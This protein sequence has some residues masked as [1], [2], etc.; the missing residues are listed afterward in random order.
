MI[1]T[2]TISPAIDYVMHTGHIISGSTNRSSKEEYYWGGKGINVS[3]M[4]KHLGIKSTALGFIAGFTGR[5]LEEG[6]NDQGIFTDFVHLENGMTR[7]N[8]K[9]KADEETEINGQGAIPGISDFNRL[10]DKLSLLSEGDILVIS[11]TIPNGLPVDTYAKILELFTVK[12]ILAAVDTSGD[13]LLNTLKHKPFLIKPNIDELKEIFGDTIEPLDGARKLH[14]AG[15]RNVIVSMGAKGAILLAEN[16][17][18]YYCGV[19][20]GEML[21]T[22]G[23]GDSM[24]AGFLAGYEET[25]DYRHALNLSVAAG[26]ATAF[27][28]GLAIKSTI[29]DCLTEIE[30]KQSIK[31][32]TLKTNSKVII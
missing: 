6:L 20:C 31:S 22:V 4:L 27:T 21:N 3:V 17:S 7:I 11:G 30:K 14:T 29:D 25:H 12:N 5:A 18:D 9:I 8:V 32:N 15:A 1:Y 23:A 13:F 16:G 28:P 24:I 19:P 2:L 26:S 10:A